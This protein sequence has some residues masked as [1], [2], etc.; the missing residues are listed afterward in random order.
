MSSEAVFELEPKPIRVN[1]TIDDPDVVNYL[2]QYSLKRRA[3][4][5]KKLMLMGLMAQRL[6]SIEGSPQPTQAPK[7]PRAERKP[8]LG[9]IL[10][11]DSLF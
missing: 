11:V 6:S 2:K 4:M 5:G 9:D 3:S 7:Q 8:D 1:V 10:G